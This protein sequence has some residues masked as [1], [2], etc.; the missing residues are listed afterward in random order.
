MIG[1]QWAPGSCPCLPLQYWD[2]KSGWPCLLLTGDGTQSSCSCVR[3]WA[4]P[5]VWEF[6]S[7]VTISILCTWDDTICI[8]YVKDTTRQNTN[9]CLHQIYSLPL[10]ECIYIIYV[11]KI[12]LYMWMKTIHPGFVYVCMCLSHAHACACMYLCS[13]MWRLEEDV[14]CLHLFPFAL[15]SQDQLLSALTGVTSPCSYTQIFI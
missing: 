15:F 10:P 8:P 2:H 9:Y 5:L 7:E 6:S 14:R 11:Y 13:H 3:S 12:H 4:I 1:C